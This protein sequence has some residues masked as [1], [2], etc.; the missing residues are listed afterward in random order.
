MSALIWT[1]TNILKGDK[2]DI[3]HEEEMDNSLTE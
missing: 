1:V 2:G 3:N